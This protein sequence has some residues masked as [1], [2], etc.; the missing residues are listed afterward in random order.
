M[1]KLKIGDKVT[2][3]PYGLDEPDEG[4]Y[5]IEIDYGNNVFFIGNKDSFVDLVPANLLKIINCA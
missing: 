5:V 3:H 1:D 2:Y 4:E